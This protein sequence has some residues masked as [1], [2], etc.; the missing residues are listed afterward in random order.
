[1]TATVKFV[2]GSA[3]NVLTVP[4]GAL[5]FTPAVDASTTAAAPSA[6]AP[7]AAA[8]GPRGA[9]GGARGT[10]SKGTLWSVDAQGQLAKHVVTT[11]LTDGQRT[12]VQG[13][14]LVEGMP[15]VIGSST[16]GAAPAA[17]GTTNPLQPST[18][19]GGR[20]GPGPF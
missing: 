9:A 3:S 10:R 8:R 14:G 2:T 20:G 18:A 4:S 12:Q 1:M 13:D 17:A 16:A 7:S 19:R 15:I 6:T 11:G 5:R